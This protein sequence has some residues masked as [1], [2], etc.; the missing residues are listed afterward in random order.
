MNK[1]EQNLNNSE[2]LKLGISDIS[3]NLYTEDE[4]KEL[5]YKILCFSIPDAYMIFAKRES[6][7]SSWKTI[8]GRKN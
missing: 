8:M 6:F 4:A 2:S 5:A 1:E 3:V 7:E